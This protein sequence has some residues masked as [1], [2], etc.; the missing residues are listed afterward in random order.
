MSRVTN[1]RVGIASCQNNT[2][3]RIPT[4]RM[5]VQ[6]LINCVLLANNRKRKLRTCDLLDVQNVYGIRQ[7]L[8]NGVRIKSTWYKAYHRDSQTSERQMELGL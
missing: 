4:R 5:K 7:T 3:M 2:P 8:P 6:R 1:R